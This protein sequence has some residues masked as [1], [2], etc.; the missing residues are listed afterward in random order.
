MIWLLCWVFFLFAFRVPGYGERIVREIRLDKL[1][2]PGRR[3]DLDCNREIEEMGI[4]R[5]GSPSW[6]STAEL[7]RLIGVKSRQWIAGYN[8]STGWE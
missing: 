2:F 4:G 7:Q 5:S 3:R 1:L 8:D 6:A